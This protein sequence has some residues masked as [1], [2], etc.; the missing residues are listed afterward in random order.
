[1][2]LRTGIQISKDRLTH[3]QEEHVNKRPLVLSTV[4]I[5][6]GALIMTLPLGCSHSGHHPASTTGI[7]SSELLHGQPKLDQKSAIFIAR[8]VASSHGINLSLYSD[9]KTAVFD[10]G[11]HWLWHVLFMEKVQRYPGQ[12]FS[13]ELNDRTAEAVLIP[14]R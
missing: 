8:A 4:T 13:I 11:D 10:E 3:S 6:I 9:P 2:R 14:G 5:M 12:H 7:S 1:M